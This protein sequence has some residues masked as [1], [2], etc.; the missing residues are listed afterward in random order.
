MMQEKTNEKQWL[1]AEGKF[2]PGNKRHIFKSGACYRLEQYSQKL[3]RSLKGGG[4][5][6]DSPL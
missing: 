2:K 3:E 5:F 6:V 4:F 1:E